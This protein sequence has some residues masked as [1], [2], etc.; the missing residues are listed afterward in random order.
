MDASFGPKPCFRHSRQFSAAGPPIISDLPGL[1]ISSQVGSCVE[2]E[3]VAAEL[4]FAL[5]QHFL[6]ARL[7]T[8]GGSSASRLC[9]ANGEELMRIHEGTYAY[10]LEQ[11]RDPQTQLPLNWKFTVYLLRPVE[12]IMCTGQGEN[13]EDAEEKARGAIAKLEAEKHRPAA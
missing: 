11:L 3:P 8:S 6:A 1:L 4:C 7:K 9:A 13:R 5:R 10:D 12:K 2:I